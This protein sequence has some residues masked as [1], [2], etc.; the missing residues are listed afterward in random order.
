M[1]RF[2]PSVNSR[3]VLFVLLGAGVLATVLAVCGLLFPW[4]VGD[5]VSRRTWAL[6]A[7]TLF[8]AVAVIAWGLAPTRRGV[9]LGGGL[10]LCW[11]GDV[12]GPIDFT[13][14]ATAFLTGH[15]CFAGAFAARG[16]N[17]RRTV[18]AAMILLL[19]D[20]AI[21][22]WLAPHLSHIDAVLVGGYMVAISTMVVMAV[23]GNTRPWQYSATA[24]VI[25]YV[26]DIAVA[27]WHYVNPTA[28][29]TVFCYPLYY[30]ACIMMALTPVVWQ[31]SADSTSTVTMPTK[32]L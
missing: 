4:L 23:A 24:A 7:S 17:R 12:L 32:E 14:G 29:H 1:V 30:G 25:F 27:H 2:R 11:V 8:V 13:W 20:I 21:G 31:R 22:V 3:K 19:T 5:I 26:S 9:A 28:D 18:V 15:I 10:L 16:L 6:T